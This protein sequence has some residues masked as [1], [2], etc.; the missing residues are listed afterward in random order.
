METPPHLRPCRKCGTQDI[1]LTHYPVGQQL[2]FVEWEYSIGPYRDLWVHY[3]KN[4]T[5]V[6]EFLLHR[7]RRCGFRWIGDVLQKEE[8]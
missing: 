5:V 7:C 8:L 2:G 4:G 1:L 6:K 3:T